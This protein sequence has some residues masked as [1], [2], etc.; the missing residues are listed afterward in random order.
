MAKEIETA[1]MRDYY[2]EGEH[3]NVGTAAGIETIEEARLYAHAD[4]LLEALAPF[5]RFSSSM[6]TIRIEVKTSDIDRARAAIAKA[7]SE[8]Q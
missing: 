3:F 2:V 1:W 5:V 8:E 4:D 7:R 6:P